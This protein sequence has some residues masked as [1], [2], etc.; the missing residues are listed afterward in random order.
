MERESLRELKD[1]SN[2]FANFNLFLFSFFSWFDPLQ[3]DVTKCC[4]SFKQTLEYLFFPHSHLSPSFRVSFG[5]EK[6]F[7]LVL[8]SWLFLLLVYN[9]LFLFTFCGGYFADQREKHK[10]KRE[11]QTENEGGNLGIE[12][13]DKQRE[14][15]DKE[16]GA[17]N[18]ESSWKPGTNS[19]SLP[20]LEGGIMELVWKPCFSLLPKVP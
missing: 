11:R 4:M 3:K 19:C 1:V 16:E 6:I 13:I 10:R 7:L 15:T 9:L 17:R 14:N 12:Q 18:V 20:S 8:N 2:D 5:N